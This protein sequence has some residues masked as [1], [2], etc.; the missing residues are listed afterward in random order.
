MSSSVRPRATSRTSEQNF[1]CGTA[2]LRVFLAIVGVV[3]W[4]GCGVVCGRNPREGVKGASFLSPRTLEVARFRADLVSGTTAGPCGLDLVD[5]VVRCVVG[6]RIQNQ[7][8]PRVMLIGTSP[9]SMCGGGH[10]GQLSARA[11][12]SYD[13]ALS[14]YN[15][16][17]SP[18]L[19]PPALCHV[20]ITSALLCRR[21]HSLNVHRRLNPSAPCRSFDVHLPADFVR[22]DDAHSP[23]RLRSEP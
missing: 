12:S 1:H 19:R 4:C 8:P 6:A 17:P 23:A 20:P 10:M 5:V 15:T 22:A 3:V 11:R 18:G 21:R 2:R 7:P 16:L 9:P 14:F 13:I